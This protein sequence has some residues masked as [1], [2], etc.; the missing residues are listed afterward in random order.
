[1]FIP[2]PDDEEMNFEGW[3][4]EDWVRTIYGDD[5]GTGYYSQA[6]LVCKQGSSKDAFP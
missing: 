3:T 5:I 6:L 2:E 4:E 1:M